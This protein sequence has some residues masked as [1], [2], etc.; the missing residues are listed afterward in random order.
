MQKIIT[1]HLV[2]AQSH[3]NTPELPGTEG[4]IEIECTTVNPPSRPRS[5]QTVHHEVSVPT[6]LMDAVMPQHWNS[7]VTALVSDQNDLPRY[8]LITID[9]ASEDDPDGVTDADPDPQL[10][11][12]PPLGPTPSRS[13]ART[14]SRSTS[15]WTRS[16]AT[17]PPS[18]RQN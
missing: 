8:T 5:G 13:Q 18:G 15:S 11:M 3:E 6:G 12:A 17:P 14:H 1:G 2:V 10:P 16:P 9:G 4:H 7:R